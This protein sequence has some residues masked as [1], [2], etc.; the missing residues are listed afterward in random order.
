[1]VEG[2]FFGG[3]DAPHAKIYEEAPSNKFLSSQKFF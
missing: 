3:G 1:M 2:V